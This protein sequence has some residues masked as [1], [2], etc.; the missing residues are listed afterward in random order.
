MKPFIIGIAGAHSGSGKTIVACEI[1]R[2]IKGLSAIKYTKSSLYSSII[3]NPLILSEK[4]KD[5]ARMLKAGAEKVLWIQSPPEELTSLINIA[6]SMLTGCKGIVIEGNSAAKAAN[7][8]ILIFISRD[9][10]KIKPGADILMKK[11]NILIYNGTDIPDNL[12]NKNKFTIGNIDGYM[13][14]LKNLLSKI[15]I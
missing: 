14:S 6:I 7:P 10:K 3:D 2:K 4:G 8:D 15:E 9:I 12:H 13:K 5:T 1:L 11:A